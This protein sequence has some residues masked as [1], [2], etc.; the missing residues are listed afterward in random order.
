MKTKILLTAVATMMIASLAMA[1]G[2]TGAGGERVKGYGNQQVIVN[3]YYFDNGYEYASRIQRFHNSY[4]VF[5]FYSPLFTETYWYHYTPYTWGV[6]IYD[7]WYYYGG[8]ISRYNW[9]SGFGG[10]YWWGYDPWRD[11]DP[12]MGYGWNSW[13]APGVGYHINYYLDRPYYHYPTAWDR[14]HSHNWDP[15]RPGNDFHNNHYGTEHRNTNYSTNTNYNPSHPYDNSHRSGYTVTGGRSS[16]S[17][18][19][20]AP[21]IKG[22]TQATG[23]KDRNDNGGRT[24]QT[25]TGQRRTPSQ[26]SGTKQAAGTWQTTGTQQTGNT[27]TDV[28]TTKTNPG[29]ESQATVRK[30]PAET[31]ARQQTQGNVKTTMQR[32]ETVMR[33]GTTQNQTRSTETTVQKSTENSSEKSAEAATTKS[34]AK[35][36]TNSSRGKR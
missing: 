18:V 11:Y 27:T 24:D 28:S 31:P 20:P 35:R 1:S 2:G 3:N 23:V 26:A 10:S 12:W 19:T 17:Q 4:V 33:Q 30:A 7:D 13:Y 34:D 5:D 22:R 8:G 36:R 15:R 9:R 16:G 25:K 21:D 29:R 32:R 6:S 14:W